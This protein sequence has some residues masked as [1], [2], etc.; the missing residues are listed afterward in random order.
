MDITL[1]LTQKQHNELTQHLFPGDEK[2]SVAVVLCGRRIGD[3]KHRLLAKEIYPVPNEAYIERHNLRVSWK[4]DWLIPIIEKAQ[5]EHLGILK[6]HSHPGGQAYFSDV[7]NAADE[8]LFPSLHGWVD[9]DYPHASAVLLPNGSL[10]GK[11]ALADGQF[12]PIN[13]IAIVGDDLTFYNFSTGNGMSP[14]YALRTEQAF[15]KGTTSLL[16]KLSAA[17]IGCSGTGSIVI[18]QLARLGIGHLVIVDP[19]I[20]EEKNLNRILNSTVTD[21]EQGS[22]KVEM[23]SNA[24]T[25]MGLGTTVDAHKV[26]LYDSPDAIKAIAE[27]DVVFGCMDSH[28]GRWL[29]NKIATYYLLP[30]FDV[31]VKLEADG[32]GGVNFVGGAVHYIQPGL[33]TLLSRRAINMAQIESEGLMRTNPELYQAKKRDKYIEGVNEESPAVISVNMLFAAFM[34]NEFIARIHPYRASFNKQFA[35]MRYVLSEG[36]QIIECERTEWSKGVSS[37]DVGRGDTSPLLGLPAL[38]GIMECL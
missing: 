21:A 29:L 34:V 38:S 7:D 22:S 16:G 33:S 19:D 15:G 23:L 37:K 20:I 36:E 3:K 27:C 11:A 24:I 6:V 4:T 9:D 13:R 14:G 12:A 28:E 18:E 8:L 30:Y 25:S 5:K 17:V 1:T 10:I 31:G 35:L 32:V 2:E 26:N